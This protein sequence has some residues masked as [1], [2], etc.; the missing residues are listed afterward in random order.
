MR[1][2]SL[3]LF[4]AFSCLLLILEAEAFANGCSKGQLSSPEETLDIYID[5]LREGNLDKVLECYYSDREDFKFHLPE[6]IKIMKYE[7]VKKKIYTK[8]MAEGYKAIPKAKAGDVEFDVREYF[9]GRE[10][11]FTYLLRQINQKWRI[12]SHN[13]LSQPD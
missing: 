3:F 9:N 4:L 11:M 12:I 10:E 5:A 13:S 1:Y 2:R 7:I 8:Q 6:S